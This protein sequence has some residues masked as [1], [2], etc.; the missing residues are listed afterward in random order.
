MRSSRGRPNSELLIYGVRGRRNAHS[1]D[2][3]I[4]VVEQL[5]IL[6]KN[7]CKPINKRWREGVVVMNLFKKRQR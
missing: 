2:G 7:E 5:D 1:H 3:Y 4:Y 6:W